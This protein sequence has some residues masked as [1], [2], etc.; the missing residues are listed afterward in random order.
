MKKKKEDPS[1][2]AGKGERN[3][4]PQVLLPP[5]GGLWVPDG[6]QFPESA[7]KSLDFRQAMSSFVAS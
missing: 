4:Q 5:E 2:E 3:R 1:K 7:L 6:K